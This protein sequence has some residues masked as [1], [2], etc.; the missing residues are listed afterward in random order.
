M[1]GGGSPPPTPAAPPAPTPVRDTKIDGTR[2][3]QNS[4]RRASSS[5]YQATML[6]GSGGVQGAAPTT[7]PVL[8]G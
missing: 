7:S 5:G 3:R 6:T 1:C 2:E 4:A 8:G